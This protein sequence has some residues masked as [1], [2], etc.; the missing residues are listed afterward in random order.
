MKNVADFLL[1]KT[2]V[3][4][5]RIAVLLINTRKFLK[6]KIRREVFN[7]EM[8]PIQ[9]RSLANLFMDGEIYLPF[10]APP[11]QVKKIPPRHYVLMSREG[12][13]QKVKIRNIR[14]RSIHGLIM[15][16]QK[17]ERMMDSRN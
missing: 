2:D 5:K 8:I 1:S 6:Q 13:I 4:A 3:P 7:R 15:R 16:T 12:E 9:K 14:N 10:F 17:K 11:I